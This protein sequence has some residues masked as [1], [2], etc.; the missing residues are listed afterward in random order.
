MNSNKFPKLDIS[1]ALSMKVQCSEHEGFIESICSFPSCEFQKML[2]PQCKLKN[3]E[4]LKQH[5]NYFK[6]PEDMKKTLQNENDEFHKIVNDSI[7]I[8]SDSLDKNLES[9]LEKE[10]E[11]LNKFFNDFS[12]KIVIELEN[13]KT[14]I[15]S[16]LIKKY[17]TEVKDDFHDY[18]SERFHKFNENTLI[19]FLHFYKLSENNGKISSKDFENMVNLV[20][21]SRIVAIQLNNLKDEKVKS[22]MQ[23][24]PKL[25]NLNSEDFLKKI[26]AILMNS[27]KNMYY[28]GSALISPTKQTQNAFI[29]RIPLKKGC[30]F[31]EK[32]NTFEKEEE[33]EY[34]LK[35]S[36]MNE[37]EINNKVVFFK[38]MNYI[39]KNNN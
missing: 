15:Y 5:Q 31:E 3:P 13:V 26:S 27:F 36:K 4:H 16:Q 17:F 12:Q 9:L 30:T 14:E 11:R 37:E 23:N 35:L 33:E 20:F 25:E 29:G 1:K 21:N 34:G 6:K 10:L 19:H 24:I 2:C 32:A 38:K 8:A 7:I 39:E 22:I 28:P 18:F